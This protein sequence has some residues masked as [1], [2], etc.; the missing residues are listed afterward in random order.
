MKILVVEDDPLIQRMYGRSLQQA[1]YTVAFANN[2]PEGLSAATSEHPD[3]ILMDVMMPGMDGIEVLKE[4]KGSQATA[5]IP[6]IMLSANDDPELMQHALELG[7]K[8]YLS[9][10]TVEPS[11]IVQM[12][13]QT[14]T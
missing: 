1:G 13:Q 8:R 12:V 11:Q 9:K 14:T 5:P 7:A 2:G 3:I 4:L 6:V 10:Q